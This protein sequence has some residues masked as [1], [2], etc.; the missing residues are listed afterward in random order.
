MRSRHI[1]GAA[2]F[3]GAMGTLGGQTV[4]A[5]GPSSERFVQLLLTNESA[6]IRSDMKALNSRDSNI[7]KLNAATS[8]RKIKQLEQMLTR[9]NRQIVA[10]TLELQ[11]S[12]DSVLSPPPAVSHRRIRPLLMSMHSPICSPSRVSRFKPAWA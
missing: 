1:L 8:S 10:L 6:L 11:V 5:Q 3:C 9:L 4:H 12:F 2:I 7:L